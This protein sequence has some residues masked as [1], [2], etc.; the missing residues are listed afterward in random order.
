MVYEVGS[1]FYVEHRASEREREREREMDVDMDMDEQPA[2][3]ATRPLLDLTRLYNGT[4]R[5]VVVDPE[6]NSFMEEDLC[7]WLAAL[8]QRALSAAP[9]A[10][11]AELREAYSAEKVADK[12]WGSASAPP[13]D[14]ETFVSGLRA[15]SLAFRYD[16][17]D[18]DAR[19]QAV[20][21]GGAC[22]LRALT[23]ALFLLNNLVLEYL[24]K[25]VGDV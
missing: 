3:S 8:L 24:V 22:A 14:F 18:A 19:S 10:L 11:R 12:L 21:A 15:D 9:E 1:I 13:R 7:L 4:F 17:A 16:T 5:R 6:S 2:A 25:Q 23:A 20:V